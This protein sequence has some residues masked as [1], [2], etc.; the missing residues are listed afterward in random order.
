MQ[1]ARLIPALTAFAVLAIAGVGV[2]AQDGPGCPDGGTPERPAAGRGEVPP[3]HSPSLP[4]PGSPSGPPPGPPPGRFPDHDPEGRPPGLRVPRMFRDASEEEIADILAFTGEHL[5]W[6]R[7]ELQ[8][9]RESDAERFR[10]LCRRLRFEIGQLRALRERDAEAFAKAI[11]ERQLQSR[12]QDLATKARAASAQDREALVAELRKVL[13]RRFDLELLTQE[14]HLRRLEERLDE[15]R[16]EL[17]D[18]AAHRAELVQKTVDDMLAGKIEP[19]VGPPPFGHRPPGKDD[20]SR[21]GGE[22]PPPTAP[23]VP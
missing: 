5:P 10:Q 14:A 3:P 17:K 1:P 12:A 13:E 2:P 20:R 21:F 15:V 19:E 9:L 22:K 18:R 6:V 7:A 11:E 23:P 4:P 16:R 8:R